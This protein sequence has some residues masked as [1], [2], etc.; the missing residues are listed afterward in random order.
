MRRKFTPT[1]ISLTLTTMILF[2][3]MIP[4][5]TADAEQYSTPGVTRANPYSQDGTG[6][7]SG[8]QAIT[9]TVSQN[10]I[11]YSS[12][13]VY[14]LNADG[15]NEIILAENSS[16]QIRNFTSGTGMSLITDYAVGSHVVNNYKLLSTPGLINY[17]GGT[18]TEIVY[19]NKTHAYTLSYNGTLNLLQSVAYTELNDTGSPTT[20]NNYF[21]VKCTPANTVSTAD[22]T[23]VFLLINRSGAATYTYVFVVYDLDANTVNMTALTS[24]EPT[25]FQMQPYHNIHLSDYDTDGYYEALFMIDESANGDADIQ[26]C[27]ISNHPTCT[28]MLH[29]NRAA[30]TTYTDIIVNR[31]DG[32]NEVATWAY[33]ISNNVYAKS[34]KLKTGVV[35]AEAYTSIL[36]APEGNY[37]SENLVEATDTTYCSY[38]SDVYLYIRNYDQ[39]DP[40]VNTD[41]V[42]CLSQYAGTGYVETPI[43]NTLLND[44]HG[45]FVMHQADLY[46]TTGLL[47]SQWGVQDSNIQSLPTLSNNEVTIPVDYKKGGVLDIIG[48]N[49]SRVVYYDSN[50]VNQNW[51]M[52]TYSFAVNPVCQ[53]YTYT[54]TI[55]INDNESDLGSCYATET[56][57]NGTVITNFSAQNFT[58]ATPESVSFYYYADTTGNFILSFSCKDQ[59]HTAYNTKQYS[60]LVTNDSSCSLPG[61]FTDGTYDTTNET[62]A[63]A[64][65]ESTTES[66]WNGLGLGAKAARNAVALFV[67]MLV[68]VLVFM[69]TGSSMLATS[70]IPVVLLI[71]FF[72]GLATIFPIV[73]MILVVVAWLVY[74]VIS[75]RGGSTPGG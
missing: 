32:V 38:S 47:L 39:S 69:K 34:L 48:Q 9:Y 20:I 28:L 64:T 60:V 16:L 40:G 57:P 19:F 26:A 62:S 3:L 29:E 22:D 75:G 7:W 65:F 71:M 67:A 61:A 11:P 72:V 53:S 59:Y 43:V 8:R 44:S 73:V 12:P 2:L 15:T 45:S 70:S 37:Y 13:L 27:E 49:T 74:T 33:M 10:M 54:Y 55:G 5:I 66:F 58:T 18:D 1:T 51:Q 31:L 42:L 56:W 4:L 41:S 25:N 68:A 30:G 35:L 63:A 52:T 17:N 46:G 6:Q 50:Y 23:C 14:D 36:T 24:A 21:P